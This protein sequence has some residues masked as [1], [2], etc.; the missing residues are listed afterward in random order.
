MLKLHV[1]ASCLV[2]E[3]AVSG[4]LDDPFE[5]FTQVVTRHRTTPDDYPFVCCDSVKFESLPHLILLHTSR[6][7]GLIEENQKTGSRKSL[8]SFR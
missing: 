8:Y 2:Q 4:I 1:K 7:I 5:T 6:N 3:Q